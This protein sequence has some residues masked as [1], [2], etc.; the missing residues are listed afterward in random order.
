VKR[1][2][3]MAVLGGAVTAWPL[4]ARAQ[5]P[6]ERMRRIG[7]LSVFAESDTEGQ[8]W[9]RELIQRLQELGWV[10]GRNV[11]IDFRFAGADAARISALATQLIELRPDMI[12]A[13]T[14]NAAAALRQQTLSIPIVFVQVADPVGQ[15]F[16][17]NL[18]RPEG[19]I[20]GFTNFEFSIGGKWLQVLRECAPGV[21]AVAVVFDPNLPTWAPYLRSIEAVAPTFGVRLTP[22]GVRDAADIEQ[23]L[24]AFAREPN[25]A[26]VV[27]PS[28][29]TIQH[30]QSIIAATARQRLPAV[31]PYRLFTVNGGLVSYGVDVPD[32]Y[33]RAASYVDRILRG[34]KVAE[35]PVQQP[36]KYEL[37]INLKAAKALGLIVPPMLLARADEVIE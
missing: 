27:L 23:R 17:T 35:L 5:Q 21:S 7:L 24:A 30:R 2:E 14:T 11:Q 33:K 19:N 29:V 22:A 13:A 37:T 10:N 34:A 1:R 31:Y 16:V 6:G 15:G 32:L 25:G 28:P 8:A 20:T 3:F 12:F 9:I 18:A 36:T 4:A 26:L